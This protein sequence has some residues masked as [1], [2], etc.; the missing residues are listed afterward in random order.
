[1]K[2]VDRIPWSD[3]I[4]A[5]L[6]RYIASNQ[7]VIVEKIADFPP[8]KWTVDELEH[9]YGDIEIRVLVSDSQKFAYD[10][11]RERTIARMKLHDFLER[12]VRNIGADGKYYA[13]GKSPVDQFPGLRE[14]IVLPPQLNGFVSG[15]GRFLEKNIWMSP[16]GTS[17]A[18]HFDTQENFNIQ[19]EG[20][21]S[22]WLYPPRIDG[23]YPYKLNSQ[24]SYLSPVDPRNLDST[25]YPDFPR[26]NGIEAV[27]GPGQLLYLPYSWWH[28]VDTTGH[29]NLN[30]NIWW[31]PRLKLLS[32]WQQSLRGAFVLLH[33]AGAHPHQRAEDESEKKAA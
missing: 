27:L 15:V 31:L 10:E 19:I 6:G 21:K 11:K 28:Q 25:R 12:G 2:Q 24:A 4:Q 29:G 22:F 23:M 9:R 3:D 7:P 32:L 33:R 18:L 5:V 20:E 30:V 14:E 1:M 8:A 13:L 26:D 17:T 16:H